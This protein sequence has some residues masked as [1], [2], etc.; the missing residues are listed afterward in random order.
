MSAYTLRQDNTLATIEK[1]HQEVKELWKYFENLKDSNFDK[2][3]KQ[4]AS[5]KKTKDE[6]LLFFETMHQIEATLNAYGHELDSREK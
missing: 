4:L 1:A 5:S 2:R 6:A 3:F